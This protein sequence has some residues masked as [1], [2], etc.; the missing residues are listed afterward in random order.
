[1]VLLVVASDFISI[2]C[3]TSAWR[4]Y[5]PGFFLE[6]PM[7]RTIQ[8]ASKVSDIMLVTSPFGTSHVDGIQTV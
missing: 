3:R 8:I 7:L 5:Q 2:S 6:L 4:A 1:M